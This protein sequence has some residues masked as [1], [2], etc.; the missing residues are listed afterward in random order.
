VPEGV[1]FEKFEDRADLPVDQIVLT[2]RKGDKLFETRLNPE[3]QKAAHT[4]YTVP[5]QEEEE[6]T[7]DL[8]DRTLGF[9]EQ[10]KAYL[11][12]EDKESIGKR[13]IDG[14]EAEGYR[15]EVTDVPELTSGTLTVTLWQECER[16]FPLEMTMVGEEVS[17]DKH[18]FRLATIR[19]P[20]F[21]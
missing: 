2:W 19:I 18:F 4:K 3:W 14:F 17:S 11:K 21:L 6:V 15:V 16:G 1:D 10:L 5:E 20:V 7:I 12:S 9:S 13:S 8:K